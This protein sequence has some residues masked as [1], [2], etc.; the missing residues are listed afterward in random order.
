M[1]TVIDAGLSAKS[2]SGRAGLRG[3]LDMVSRK[4]I[5]HVVTLKLDRFSRNTVEALQMVALMAKKGVDL[6]VV[7]E[8]GEVKNDSADD[9]F[10]LTLKCGL[11]QRERKI[12]GERTKF[13]LD[14]K[15]ERG[16]FCGGEAP[17][18]Y[19]WI[20]YRLVPYKPK[21]GEVV[22]DI[23]KFRRTGGRLVP[24]MEEQRIVSKIRS[25]RKRGYSIRRIVACLREDGHL[26]RRGQFFQKTQVARILAREAA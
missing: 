11:A 5:Q 9:E 4:Q 14:R 22:T 3:I 21:H 6:H 1:D 10:L 23:R 17:Y 13:A 7:S 16:E 12:I 15:R 2:V 18:G 8:Q 19:E 25:L 26:N 20:G 24:N